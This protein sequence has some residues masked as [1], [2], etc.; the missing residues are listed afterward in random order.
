M[1][2][3][4][5]EVDRVRVAEDPEAVHDLRVAL[6]RCRSVAAVLSEV[7]PHPAWRDL[8]KTGKKLFRRLGALRDAQ[9]LMDWTQRLGRA[10][11]SIRAGLE[12]I[13]AERERT[14]RKEALL[15][16]AR[17]DERHWKQLSR[18]LR[19][20]SR[21]VPSNG[22]AARCLALERYED[23]YSL[24]ARALRNRSVASWHAL[25]IGI[26]RFR[27]TVEILLPERYS[28]W[29]DALKRLQ[30]LLG[31]VH[32]LD[33]LNALLRDERF[34]AEESAL[35]RWRDTIATER[36]PRLREYRERAAGKGGLW[37]VW[38][39][40]LPQESQIPAAVLARLRATSAALDPQ[41]QKTR[42]VSQ[43]AI[44]LFRAFAL[45]RAAPLFRERNPAFLLRGAAT[46][47]NIGRSH[48][49]KARHKA[50]QDMILDFALPPAWSSED[51][52]EL[53]CVVRYHRGTEPRESHRRFMELPLERRE[54]VFA[55]SGVLR[56]ARA[57]RRA[58]VDPAAT[59]RA[60]LS[61]DGV[62]LL[63]PGLPD[64]ETNAAR[65][66]AG[67]HL[68]ETFLHR[69]IVVQPAE[70]QAAADLQARAAS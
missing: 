25:R 49:R 29:G 45:A 51:L 57:L 27:Y 19:E 1:G 62:V 32:D 14:A 35:A 39:A 23:A 37:Q 40:G 36:D 24:H 69:P 58:G 8:R 18:A 61:F 50:A 26:K 41:P 42:E 48:R 3:V 56:L 2:R 9:V 59:L 22:L 28:E 31:E 43:I 12:E 52:S 6:R 54:R 46:L 4:L 21:L 17:F 65:I 63:V 30:D 67:K 33:T 5:D 53:A 60:E 47:L 44:S 70:N 7:D 34:A 16:L 38:R 11:G 15:A 68:L 64:T 66:A 20:R 13:L 10:N 55:L